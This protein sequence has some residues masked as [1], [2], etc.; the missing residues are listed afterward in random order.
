MEFLRD[1][2]WVIVVALAL[3]LA[4][5]L[6]RPKQNVKLTDTAPVRRCVLDARL[7]E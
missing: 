4:F 6:L 5:I 7:P 1:Y 3:V 2:W